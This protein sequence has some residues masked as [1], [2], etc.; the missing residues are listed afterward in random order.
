MTGII[1]D[2][3]TAAQIFREIRRGRKEEKEIR[4]RY[5]RRIPC[6][7]TGPAFLDTVEGCTLS[8]CG[9]DIFKGA[10][11]A[12]T[13]LSEKEKNR[14]LSAPKDGEFVDRAKFWKALLR[15]VMTPAQCR[16]AMTATLRWYMHIKRTGRGRVAYGME[17]KVIL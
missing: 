4:V 7:S 2:I 15:T 3:E 5:S 9:S 10:Q 17:K 6:V 12:F 8:N 16:I 14:F 1:S 13:A 11:S